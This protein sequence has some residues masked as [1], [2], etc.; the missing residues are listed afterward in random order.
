MRECSNCERLKQRISDLKS[1][2]LVMKI[3]AF[4]S[5]MAAAASSQPHPPAMPPRKKTPRGRM[6]ADPGIGLRQAST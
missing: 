3:A 4:E 5:K 6:E 1:E 2:L